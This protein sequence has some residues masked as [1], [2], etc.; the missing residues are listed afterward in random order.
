[1]AAPIIILRFLR[2]A[3][4]IRRTVHRDDAASLSL[5]D[6]VLSTSAIHSLLGMF[7]SP[8]TGGISVVRRRAFLHFLHTCS[9]LF[10][11][12]PS[13]PGTQPHSE[14]LFSLDAVAVALG[15]LGMDMPSEEW[16]ALKRQLLQAVKAYVAQ[17]PAEPQILPG[18]HRSDSAISSTPSSSSAL[19]PLGAVG[20]DTQ[21]SVKSLSLLPLPLPTDQQQHTGLLEYESNDDNDDAATLCFDLDSMSRD[22]LCALVRSQSH[23]ITQKDATIVKR[24]LRIV[25]LAATCQ[26]FRQ[27]SRRL[28]NRLQLVVAAAKAP[29]IDE[30]FQISRIGSRNLTPQ[31]TIALGL[32]RNLG[33]L[34]CADI[35][36]VVLQ[37]ID[38]TTVSRAEK[39]TGAA[40]MASSRLFFSHLRLDLF[41]TEDKLPFNLAVHSF[42]T[43]G[44]NS[45]IWQRRKLYALELES[46]FLVDAIPD[47]G[48]DS[49]TGEANQFILKWPD[50]FERL[51]R[52]SDILPVEDGTGPGTVALIMKQ[53]QALGCPTWSEIIQNSHSDS[54]A[55]GP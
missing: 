15:E 55:C 46:A 7:S 43:D 14:D 48:I 35:G 54:V 52:V 18:L 1:M 44:T 50:M 39:K 24:D 25:T 28:E 36:H 20:A 17:A 30:N 3:V 22:D 21:T 26:T 37:D 31:G 23:K 27:K 5:D 47:H 42:R 11:C 19:V 6:L 40:L 12:D 16:L 13:R 38:G 2:Q 49:H 33:N 53:L 8:A 29:V 45:S 10:R 34:A 9:E 32:R 4:F 41:G 51:K